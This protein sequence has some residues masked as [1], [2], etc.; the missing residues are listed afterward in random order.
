[1][2]I[3]CVVHNQ[4]NKIDEASKP[5]YNQP[6]LQP[7]KSQKLLSIKSI[8]LLLAVIGFIVPW[9]LLLEFIIQHGLYTQFFFQQAFANNVS[10]TFVVDLLLSTDV[11]LF[12]AFIELK[13]LGFSRRWLLLYFVLTLASG[14]CCSLPLFLYFREQALEKKV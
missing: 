5:M 14:L 3:I 13:R 8:Y 7:S 4:S 12:F 10:T 2:F 6:Y 9:S 1:M 11:F